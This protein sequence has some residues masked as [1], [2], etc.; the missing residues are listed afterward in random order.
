MPNRFHCA[1]RRN[2]RRPA[3]HQDE[4]P[5]E[6]SLAGCSPAE[7]ASASSATLIFNQQLP[8]VQSLPANGN[9]P[10]TS[11]SHLVAHPS[12]TDP[13]YPKMGGTWGDVIYALGGGASTNNFIA[14]SSATAASPIS[15][16][17]S[18]TSPKSSEENSS[19][20]NASV[21]A[22]ATRCS[23]RPSNQSP[24]AKDFSSQPLKRRLAT[25]RPR[26][27][28]KV[29]AAAPSPFSR[30][31]RLLRPASRALQAR[32]LSRSPRLLGRTALET[33]PVVTVC[34]D[35]DQ[36]EQLEKS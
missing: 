9:C 31:G 21:C 25:R 18:A 14:D 1:G 36:L 24:A 22:W 2:R 4:F 26:K 12:T 34:G 23:S 20:G 30:P 15:S 27:A 11:L 7:P 16:S 5:T 29:I 32:P 19:L 17:S 28:S 35:S 6:Y 33:R 3:P 10:Q 13:S 8:F